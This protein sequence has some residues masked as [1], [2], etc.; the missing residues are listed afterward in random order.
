MKGTDMTASTNETLAR[1]VEEAIRVLC[2]LWGYQV[3]DEPAGNDLD[4]VAGELDVEPEVDPNAETAELADIELDVDGDGDAD[5]FVAAPM[6]DDDEAALK[7]EALRAL[8]EHA[9]ALRS[10]DTPTD[11]PTTRPPRRPV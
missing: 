10:D 5:L 8:S 11:G 4:S 7:R 9:V 3:S 6:G 2:D 1:G